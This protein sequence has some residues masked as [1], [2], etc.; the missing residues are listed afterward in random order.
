MIKEKSKNHE[1][2]RGTLLTFNAPNYG[3]T[4]ILTIVSEKRSH[5]K[6]RE[7]LFTFDQKYLTI[8]IEEKNSRKKL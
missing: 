2:I 8:F 6:I 7:T 4:F 5:E 1:N 3:N